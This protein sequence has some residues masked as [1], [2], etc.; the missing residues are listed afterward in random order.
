MDQVPCVVRGVFVAVSSGS[1]VPVIILDTGG[2]ASIPIFIGLWEA[3]SIN[4]ALNN[5]IPPRPLTHDLIVNFMDRYHITMKALMIDSIEE[6]VFYAKMVLVHEQRE[7]LLD[8]RPSDGIAVAIRCGAGIYLDSSVISSS[9]VKA[10]DLPDLVGLN[11]YL[12]D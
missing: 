9:S 2:D 1:P 3:I 8:C 6:G 12:C 11:S 5:E 10:G 4:N 7:E